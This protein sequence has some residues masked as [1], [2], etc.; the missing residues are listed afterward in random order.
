MGDALIR[1]AAGPE[2]SAA[3]HRMRLRATGLLVIAGIMGLA[4]A[5]L[6]S[7]LLLGGTVKDRLDSLDQAHARYAVLWQRRLAGADGDAAPSRPPPVSDPQLRQAETDLR[8]QLAQLRRFI[9]GGSVTIALLWLGITGLGAVALRFYSNLAHAIAAV[10]ARALAIVAG[11]RSRAAPGARVDEL[12]ELAQALD[13]LAEALTRHERDLEIER[14]HVMHRE[15]LAAIGSMAAGVLREINHPIA[16]IDGYARALAEARRSDTGRI[17][18][19][20]FD[21]GEILRETGRLAA[22]THDIA[23]LA[24]PPPS[25]WQLTSLNET[26]TQ[27]LALL[28][29]EP[30]L[31]GVAVAADLDSQLPAVM[32]SAGRLTLLLINLVINSA[33]ATAGLPPRAAHIQVSTRR[34]ADGVELS[35]SD[36]GCGMTGA[37]RERAFEP[38]F[39]TKPA[40][41]GTGLGLPLCRAIAHEHGGRIE[42]ESAAATGT[43][44]TVWFPFDAGGAVKLPE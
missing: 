28:R 36:N 8:E 35:V 27:A 3:S 16:A 42:L 4:L 25:S 23:E 22:I 11:D 10:R 31:E 43:R 32:A 26:V 9:D 6:A 1:A 18:A 2:R 37:V 19:A 12:G 39:T 5:L 34:A 41:R 21:P 40:G 15:K 33:D 24:A 30:R 29:Y 38:L 13:G 7:A 44:V 14:R 20:G 17:D